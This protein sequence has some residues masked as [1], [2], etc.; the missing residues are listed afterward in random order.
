[1]QIRAAA[2]QGALTCELAHFFLPLFVHLLS[3]SL[4]WDLNSI[5]L[6]VYEHYQSINLI[7]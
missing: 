7:D 6:N 1:M 5:L 3:G 4:T 2:Q